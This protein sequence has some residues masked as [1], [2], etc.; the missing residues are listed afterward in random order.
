M[1]AYTHAYFFTCV[2]LHTRRQSNADAAKEQAAVQAESS[3]Q[4]TTIKRL[5]KA[6]KDGN[7]EVGTSWCVSACAHR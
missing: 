5:M 3:Q 7:R 6:V 2:D 4:T 1:Q